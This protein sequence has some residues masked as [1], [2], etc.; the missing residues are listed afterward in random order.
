MIGAG[1]RGSLLI[2]IMTEAEGVETK[3]LCEVDEEKG[4]RAMKDLEEIQ[5]HAPRRIVDSPEDVPRDLFSASEQV[6]ERTERVGSHKNRWSHR[7]CRTCIT[8]C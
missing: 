2:K 1:A 6:Y 4:H 8:A 3:Y 5:G 7:C